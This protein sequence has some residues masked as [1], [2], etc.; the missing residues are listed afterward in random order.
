MGKDSIS[1]ER[2]GLFWTL[3]ETSKLISA[4]RCIASD[5]KCH[6]LHPES[7]T[8]LLVEVI[9]KGLSATTAEQKQCLEL[10]KGP[11]GCRSELDPTLQKSHPPVSLD[12]QSRQ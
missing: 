8:T 7:G 3:L 5:F 6:L 4:S 12:L 1:S 11:E 9:G 10:I 2:T